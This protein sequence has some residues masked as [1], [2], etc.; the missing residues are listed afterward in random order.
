MN[1][2]DRTYPQRAD[3]LVACSWPGTTS[4]G[5]LVTRS[6][7]L[8]CCPEAVSVGAGFEGRVAGLPA[9]RQKGST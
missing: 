3:G 2:T 7:G 5:V 6:L 8:L 1:N 4:L 9:C